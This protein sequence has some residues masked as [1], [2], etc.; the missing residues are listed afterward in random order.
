[1]VFSNTTEY[2]ELKRKW[3]STRNEEL[4]L[5]KTCKNP[6]A[7]CTLTLSDIRANREYLEKKL[8]EKEKTLGI[9]TT[10]IKN[11]KE[12]EKMTE[13]KKNL[14]S[15]IEKVRKQQ[16]TLKVSA[17]INAGVGGYLLLNHC[18]PPVQ[19]VG[20]ILGPLALSQAYIHYN[21]SKKMSGIENNLSKVTPFD[22]STASETAKKTKQAND[23]DDP[24]LLVNGKP[25]SEVTFPCPGGNGGKNCVLE[26]DASTI[27]PVNGGPT[28]TISELAGHKPIGKE[29]KKAVSAALNP[30]KKLIK[31]LKRMDPQFN[32]VSNLSDETA[33]VPFMANISSGEGSLGGNTP[34]SSATVIPYKKDKQSS[35]GGQ[36]NFPFVGGV[37][38]DAVEE[39]DYYGGYEE[40]VEEMAEE[41]EDM[42]EEVQ[43]LLDKFSGKNEKK[44]DAAT[45]KPLPFG[46]DEK[47]SQSGRNFFDVIKERYQIY[48]T[49]GGFINNKP[50]KKSR[51][52]SKQ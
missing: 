50:K 13:N 10:K 24:Q 39:G 32:P 47:I 20:C 16:K 42:E 31:V 28:T 3:E 6:Q 29:A 17:L 35:S 37:S 36:N 1:M 4:A 21:Q 15:S 48:R 45:K 23:S 51:A 11:T 2:E 18:K 40:E 46:K 30:Q 22:T 12:T 49:R 8:K 43:K 44:A 33:S 38:N 7:P 27:R 5:E 25:I 34:P 52:P 26:Q 19:K 41:E 9:K 14:E